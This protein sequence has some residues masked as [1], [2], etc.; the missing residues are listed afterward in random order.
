MNLLRGPEQWGS[1]WEGVTSGRF[2]SAAPREW[3]LALMHSSIPI[4]ILEEKCINYTLLC[5][6]FLPASLLPH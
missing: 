2:I 4:T 1:S 3:Y 5:G 6:I